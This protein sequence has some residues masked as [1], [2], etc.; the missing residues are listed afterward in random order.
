M[1]ETC[2]CAYFEGF[3]L[4]ELFDFADFLIFYFTC[5]L[6]MITLLATGGR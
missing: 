4:L 6:M 2:L 5:D 1:V 3:V